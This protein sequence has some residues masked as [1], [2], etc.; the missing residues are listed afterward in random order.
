MSSPAL[1]LPAPE[2]DESSPYALVGQARAKPGKAEALQA[3][4]LALVGPTRKEDGALQYHVHRDRDDPD[5]F[6]FYEVWASVAHLEAHLSQPYVQSFLQSR[7]TLLA[8]D[9]DVRWLRMASP[10]QA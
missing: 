9:L 8:G 6:V 5:V 1:N 2:R 3:A 10:Y 7:H 4:L